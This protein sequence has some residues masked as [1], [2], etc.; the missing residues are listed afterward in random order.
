MRISKEVFLQHVRAY[1]PGDVIFRE[2]EPGKEMFIL[3]DGRVEITKSTS[4]SAA[5]TLITLQRGDIFGEMAVI[6]KKARAAT[7]TAIGPTKVLV[8]NEALFDAT[9]EK[10]PDFARK[11]IKLL[12]DR[13][14]R[15]NQLLQGALG[16][17]R[18][19]L[20]MDALSEYAS[21][22]GSSTFRGTR[23]NVAEF[24]AWASRHIGIDEKDIRALVDQLIKRQILQTS[25]LG[26]EEVLVARKAPAAP[27]GAGAAA[28][29]R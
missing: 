22:R 8:L 26:K 25:A 11:I 28:T 2:G 6:D 16:A 29:P 20:V 17:N 13:L 9:L 1:S 27:T 15:T 23:I 14:R 21:E 5:K 10:N 24:V 4:G 7:A 12:S 18:Q 3:V 19:S